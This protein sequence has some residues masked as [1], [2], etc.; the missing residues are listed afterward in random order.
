MYISQNNP[1]RLLFDIFVVILTVFAALEVPLSLA[2]RYKPGFELNVIIALNIIFFSAYLVLNFFTSATIEG[3]EVTDRKILAVRYLKTWF[4]VDFMAA[5]PF[6]WIE[7]GNI[8]DA[9]N[10]IMTFRLFSPRIRHVIKLIGQIRKDHIFPFLKNDEKKELINPGA[11]R[12]IFTL[13]IVMLIAHWISCGWLA[14]GKIDD[15]LDNYT[16]YLKAL[17]WATTTITTIGYGDITP[18]TN[19][20]TIFTMFVQLLGAGMYGYVIGNLAS[21]LANSDLARTQ[22]R[23]RIEKI[24]T[25]MRYKDVPL[26]LQENIKEY[27]DYLWNNRRGFDES[28]VLDDLPQSLKIQVA[29]HLNR[30]IIAKVP[31]FNGASDDL[32]QQIVLNLKPVLYTPGDFIFRKGEMGD[33]MFFI[34][35]GHVEIVSEDGKNVFATLTDGSFFGEIA[36]LFSSERTASVR[37]SDYCDLY[38]LDKETFDNVLSKFPNIAAQVHQMAEERR[39]RMSIDSKASNEFETAEEEKII[40]SLTGNFQTNKIAINWNLLSN[41]IGYQITRWDDA[42][43][44]WQFLSRSE[45]S[46]HFTDIQPFKN[47]VNT[48]RVRA[49]FSDE[50]GEWS[51]ALHINPK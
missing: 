16:N 51:M 36:L 12:L 42:A 2:L 50:T 11:L 34:S 26:D 14:L 41:A 25:F 43:G 35:R 17:Y 27:Y 33:K 19:N 5:I 24:N 32:I 39:A 38:T 23:A 31:M 7:W 30:D 37:A 6:A 10:I 3:K 29:L 18:S 44:K 15:K 9:A 40:T 22:F 49:I 13:M 21:L 20:Q 4:V 45:A 48:Y 8:S 46:N 28:A 47:S 1:Y